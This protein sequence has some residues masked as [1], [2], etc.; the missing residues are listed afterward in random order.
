MAPSDFHHFG[1]SH[2]GLLA[3]RSDI[4]IYPTLPQKKEEIQG[5]FFKQ[6]LI[7]L[8]SE[9]SFSPMTSCYT[10]VKKPSLPDYFRENN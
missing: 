6:R 7:G 3:I 9:F 2:Y 8:N 1:L 4:C 5:Q 10:K